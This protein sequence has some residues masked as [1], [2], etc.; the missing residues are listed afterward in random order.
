MG[1]I[2]LIIKVDIQRK[3]GSIKVQSFL[4]PIIPKKHV[5]LTITLPNNDQPNLPSKI[6]PTLLPHPNGLIN[7]T[8]DSN[9][10]ISIIQNILRLTSLR[11]SELPS[12]LNLRQ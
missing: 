3:L 11:P 8:A 10:P 9:K 5:L 7:P 6:P 4:K 2:K 12:Y 1:F